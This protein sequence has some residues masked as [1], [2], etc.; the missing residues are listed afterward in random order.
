[1]SQELLITLGA[2]LIIAILIDGIRRARHS[3]HDRIRMSRRKQPI[4][5]EDSD[6]GFNNYGSEL[7]NGGARVISVRDDQDA[8]QLHGEIRKSAEESK[9][10][11]AFQKSE[12]GSQKSEAEIP[13]PETSKEDAAPLAVR[14]PE[15]PQPEA[16]TEQPATRNPQPETRSEQPAARS[17]KPAAK[18]PKRETRSTQPEQATLELSPAKQKRDGPQEVIA[19]HLR[20]GKDNKFAGQELLETLVEEGMRFGAMDIFHRH[21]ESDG[22][23]DVLFSIANSVEP[24]T[25]DLNTIGDLE[26]P[27]ISF[28]IDLGSV[29]DPKAAFSTMLE[30]I[31]GCMEKLGGELKDETGSAVTKQTV[32]HYKQRVRDFQRRALSERV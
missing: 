7:P 1:M 13:D 20:S 30:T 31:A 12:V 8:E 11:L 17:P 26:T 3:R 14:E 5:D 9:P 16:A 27:G 28:F 22:S 24:G 25:F 29:D 32:E 4:F 23:G 15:A 2:L 21:S 19:F 6:D 10:K 18:S